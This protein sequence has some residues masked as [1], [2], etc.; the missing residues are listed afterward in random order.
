MD[1]GV[2]L[3]GF[4]I[5]GEVTCKDYYARTQSFEPKK[6]ITIDIFEVWKITLKEKKCHRKSLCR[7]QLFIIVITSVKFQFIAFRNVEVL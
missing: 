3:N 4:F 5:I 2:I 1:F 7:T 6:Q